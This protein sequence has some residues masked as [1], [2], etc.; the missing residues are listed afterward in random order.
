MC[1]LY[2]FDNQPIQT[3]INSSSLPVTGVY[4]LSPQ[5][6]IAILIK[7]MNINNHHR[8]LL[9]NYHYLWLLITI[10]PIDHT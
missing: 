1:I 5:A 10:Q 2:D 8:L 7:Q 6:Q 9:T 3:I 4:Q